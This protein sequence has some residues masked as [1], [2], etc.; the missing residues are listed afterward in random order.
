[1]KKNIL[2]IILAFAMVLSLAACGDNGSAG[3]GNG[4]LSQ[5]ES[6]V[7]G[8]A[9]DSS[10]I[11]GADGSADGVIYDADGDL[12][13]YERY[14]GAHILIMG[15][16]GATLDGEALAEYDY[17]W[18]ADPSEA[19][20][21]VKNSPAEYHTGT[22]PDTEAA[23]YIAHD[24]YYFPQLDEDSFKKVNY[25]GE[26]EWAYY[27]TAEGYED[28]IF[29]TLPVFMNSADF[30]SEMMH[31][32]EE[33]YE[34]PVIH[35][36]QPGTYILEGS[37]Q[38]Q[39]W[40]E[41][42]DKDESFADESAKITLVL[43][44]VSVE[45]TVAP[46]LVIYSAYEADNAWEERT[47]Y[48]GSVDIS[49]AGAN[50]VIAD[51][52][53]NDF[54]GANIYSMLKTKLKNE[55]DTSEIPVQKKARKIDGAFYSFVSMNID[56]ESSGSGVL[57]IRS[58]TFEGLDTE[59]HLA[60]NG[61]NINIYAADDGINCNEDHVSSVMFNGGT[62]HIYA[63]LGAEGD[64]ID[65]NGFIVVNGGTLISVASPISDN[66]LDSEDGVEING[67]TVVALGSGMGGSSYT[68]Y[69]DGELQYGSSIGGN[70]GFP[71]FGGGT[72]P[73][74]GGDT[75]PGFGGD[76]SFPNFGEGEGDPGQDGTDGNGFPGFGGNGGM[77]G[78]RQDGQGGRPGPRQNGGNTF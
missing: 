57:N 45:C 54:T 30:P 69:V 50:I 25:D 51:E 10:D 63:G 15:D 33:A 8:S 73:G 67:G 49:S 26:Q 3:G 7:S 72:F 24:I 14:P 2:A 28:Y 5:T 18:N 35:I 61:G 47:E 20:D 16:E 77:P 1:M 53:V 66:G 52:T 78:Y 6:G 59:L 60:V 70:G 21:E 68:V 13:V 48:S 29:A 19:H 4:G 38:G 37:W 36:T 43:N 75:F 46:S 22:A 71:G 9:G 34:N 44:G 62:T 55:E 64:G 42:G 65:S 74:F 41:L 23:A 12:S 32:A 58:T 17:V 27:Y 76:G 11:S 39:I 31:S 40:V 56:G